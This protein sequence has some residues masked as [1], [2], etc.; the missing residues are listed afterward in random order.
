[1]SYRYKYY[2]D[3]VEC[4]TSHIDVTCEIG[5]LP[6][7]YIY[8]SIV[9]IQ[10]GIPLVNPPISHVTSICDVLHSTPSCMNKIMG[11]AESSLMQVAYMT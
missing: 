6:G 2:G 4:N 3:G 11:V 7:E 8:Y 9:Y 5:G 10:K 1:M